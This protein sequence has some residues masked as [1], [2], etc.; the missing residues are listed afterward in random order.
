MFLNRNFKNLTE[1]LKKKTWDKRT[2][3]I[4]MAKLLA[5]QKCVQT[6]QMDSL[7]CKTA[8]GSPCEG[9]FENYG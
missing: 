5:V 1:K 7:G 6:C 9:H 2:Y 8:R 4:F 3:E